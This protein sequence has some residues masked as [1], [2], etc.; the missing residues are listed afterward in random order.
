VK[1][2][3]TGKRESISGKNTKPETEKSKKS[4]TENNGERTKTDDTPKI[5]IPQNRLYRKR[6]R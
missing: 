4:D 1:E 6:N 5:D 2:S 3:I